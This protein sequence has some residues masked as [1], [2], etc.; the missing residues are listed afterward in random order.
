MKPE[1]IIFGILLIGAVVLAA[2][3]KEDITSNDLDLICNT[4]GTFLYR[5][6]NWTCASIS[7]TG[8]GNLS[9]TENSTTI[10]VEPLSGKDLCLG[11]CSR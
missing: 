6:T 11:N 5:G 3:S 2:M 9:V 7:I 10:K 1:T 4:T 8:I